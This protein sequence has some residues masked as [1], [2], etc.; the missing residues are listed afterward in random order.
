MG[1]L[2]VQSPKLMFKHKSWQSEA[3]CTAGLQCEYSCQNR[4]NDIIYV[5]LYKQPSSF[6]F[7]T[8]KGGTT[9][10]NTRPCQSVTNTALGTTSGKIC[11][12]IAV[13][14][15]DMLAGEGV[16]L[17]PCDFHIWDSCEY[18]GL[19]STLTLAGKKKNQF[20]FLW[21]LVTW[22]ELILTL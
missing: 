21:K 6:S 18:F 8:W 3:I 13:L 14:P 4:I 15:A 2:N 16:W 11:K 5:C 20:I 22:I 10:V 9:P 1:L 7:V 17:F 12:F 19:G